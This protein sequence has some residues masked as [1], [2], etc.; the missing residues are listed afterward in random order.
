MKKKTKCNLVS[1]VCFKLVSGQKESKKFIIILVVYINIVVFQDYL[2][3]FEYIH[4]K[5]KISA[6]LR[7]KKYIFWCCF[8]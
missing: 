2:I 1:I 7:E 4:K 3:N 6:A 8:I 5:K